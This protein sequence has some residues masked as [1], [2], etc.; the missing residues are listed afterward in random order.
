MF[1]WA[2][3]FI[4][5]AVAGYLTLAILRELDALPRYLTVDKVDREEAE[6]LVRLHYCYA[7]PAYLMIAQGYVPNPVLT[8]KVL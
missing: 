5:A 7:V 6:R 8:R 3:N 4:K 1:R 2:Y